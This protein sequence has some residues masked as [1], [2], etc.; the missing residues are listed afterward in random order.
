MVTALKYKDVYCPD[1]ESAVHYFLGA[2]CYSDISE[3]GNKKIVLPRE[4]EEKTIT[5]GNRKPPE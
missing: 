5:E 1:I 4:R 2:R 3:G